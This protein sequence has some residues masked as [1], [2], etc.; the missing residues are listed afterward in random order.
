MSEWLQDL[1]EDPQNWIL[2]P[3][4][5]GQ[6][7]LIIAS[8]GKT[9]A[10]S[11]HG[12]LTDIFMSNLPGGSAVSTRGLHEHAI[13]DCIY[14]RQARRYYVLDMMA[15]KGTPFYECDTEFRYFF[16][17]SKF[18]EVECARVTPSNQRVFEPLRP[19]GDL[20]AAL[21]WRDFK[22]DGIRFIHKQTFYTPGICT[23]LCLWSTPD[24]LAML[25]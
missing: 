8:G 18:Q 2:V 3:C 6:R 12:K 16:M 22:V 13:L 21:N 5:E 9:R 20:H 15:W 14:Q 23:P 17:T 10:W 1:P 19:A 4:P 7:R 11:R 25:I 24:K